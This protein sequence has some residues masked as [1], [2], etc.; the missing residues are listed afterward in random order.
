[1][2]VRYLIK[3]MF[4]ASTKKK[5]ISIIKLSAKKAHKKKLKLDGLV[6]PISSLSKTLPFLSQHLKKIGFPL[7][8]LLKN[9]VSYCRRGL[10]L[11]HPSP[12]PPPST[13]GV[14]VGWA[15]LVWPYGFNNR[16]PDGP[17]Y[18]VDV[19]S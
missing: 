5:T 11:L 15:L 2:F 18:T 7:S 17:P 12:T 16:S 19:L 10:R 6:E 1:M 8:T 13:V 3:L 9:R 14:E 4:S